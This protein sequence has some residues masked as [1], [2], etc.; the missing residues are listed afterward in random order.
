[1]LHAGKSAK[2]EQ[3]A[4]TETS[5]LHIP[6]AFWGLGGKLLLLGNL[7]PFMRLLHVKAGGICSVPLSSFSNV[8]K[9]WNESKQE[10]GNKAQSENP[11]PLTQ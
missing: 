11:Q 1:M 9:K 4:T 10:K 6:V 7:A 3:R 2:E 8:S 5:C